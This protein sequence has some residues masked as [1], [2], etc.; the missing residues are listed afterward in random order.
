MF[1]GSIEEAET[2]LNSDPAVKAGRF[3]TEL[4]PM[5]MTVGGICPVGENYEMIQYKFLKYQPVPEKFAEYSEKKLLKLEKRHMAFMKENRFKVDMVSDAVFGPDKGGMLILDKSTQ[6][7]V[8]K[9]IKFDP[10]IKY[11]LY[12]V[13]IKNLWIAKGSFCER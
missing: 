10:W 11:E 7:L 3:I 1:A 5:K 9:T 12:R 8:D 2:I 13:D 6:E 4:Y